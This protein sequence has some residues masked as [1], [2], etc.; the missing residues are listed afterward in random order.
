MKE[1]CFVFSYLILLESYFVQTLS[2]A[3]KFIQLN[4]TLTIYFNYE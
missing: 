4:T 1:L 2:I 3:Q